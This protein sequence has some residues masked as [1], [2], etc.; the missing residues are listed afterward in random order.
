MQIDDDDTSLLKIFVREAITAN[1][2]SIHSC[3]NNE[4]YEEAAELLIKLE[5]EKK[6]KDKYFPELEIN[7]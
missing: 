6:F 5:K 7:Y 2:E 4:R 3:I 1:L